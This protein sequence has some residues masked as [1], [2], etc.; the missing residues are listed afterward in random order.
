MDTLPYDS[1]EEF[2]EAL[3]RALQTHGIPQRH[4]AA[5]AGVSPPEVNRWVRGHRS[6]SLANMSRLNRALN[7]LIYDG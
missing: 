7:E 3:R 6:P 5:K 1:P 4:L 2:M